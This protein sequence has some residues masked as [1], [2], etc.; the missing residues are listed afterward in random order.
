MKSLLLFALMWKDNENLEKVENHL[1]KFYGQFLLETASFELPYSKY[2]FEE[3]GSPLFKK[4]VATNYL[5]DHINLANIKKHCMF[6]ED[7]Y[8]KNKNR[9][10]NIDPIL[11]DE[12]K[13]LVATKK[14]RG[15]RIQID[16]DIFVEI[17]LWYHS[18]E[19]K[20]FLWTYLDY[21]ENSDF[22]LKARKLLKKLKKEGNPS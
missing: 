19:F 1:K 11:V 14:Y 5:T 9:T 17:E 18:K 8:R 20:S 12:E 16:K 21:K 15:N 4:F 7:R 2:Y 13:V 22:F 3:M 6:I 10:V